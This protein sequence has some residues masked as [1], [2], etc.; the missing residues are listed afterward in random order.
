MRRKCLGIAGQRAEHLPGL[1]VVAVDRLLA[2]ND[3]LRLLLV[4]HGL[5]QLGDRK[6]VQ[7]VVGLDQHGAVGAQRQRG[8]Q[9]LL[10]SGRTDGDDNDFAR[11]ALLFQAYGFFHGNFAEGVHRHLDVGEVNARIVRLDAN[12]DVVIDHSFDSYKNL[13]GFLVTLR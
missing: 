1:V 7:F 12:L 13:H 4:D 3:Q 9:L 11:H 2:E 10:G 5:E 8:A 6:G